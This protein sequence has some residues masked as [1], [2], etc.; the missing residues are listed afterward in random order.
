MRTKRPGKLVRISSLLPNGQAQ[1]VVPVIFIYMLY[2]KISSKL[3]NREGL[4]GIC[5]PLDIIQEKIGFG[6]SKHERGGPLAMIMFGD[7]NMHP[8]LIIC[9]PSLR[10]PVA[11][12]QI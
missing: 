8:V 12:I 7:H 6:D 11:S 9:H 2:V 4:L 5:E 10:L 1:V 3:V